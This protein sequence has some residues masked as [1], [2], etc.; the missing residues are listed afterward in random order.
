MADHGL[1]AAGVIYSIVPDR[2][3]VRL[4]R[5]LNDYGIGDLL[6]IGHA[7]AALPQALLGT[8]R[9]GPRQP[10]LVVNLSLGAEIP[11]PARLL[12]RWLPETAKSADQL[13]ARLPELCALLDRVHGNLSDVLAWL[14]ARGVLVV[15]A[16]GND[17]LRQ[18][19][20]PGQPPPPRYPARYDDVLGV[21]AVRRDL[22]QPALYS[23]RGDVVLQ[24]G[25]G[26][27]ATFGGNVMPAA[28]DQTPPTTSP[29]D[30]V[31][32]IFSSGVLPDETANKTGWVKWSGTSF[33]T[34]IVAGLA[35]RLWGTDRSRPPVGL[36]QYVRSFAHDM[37]AGIN[38]NSPLEVP[39]LDVSQA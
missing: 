26:H 21:A 16:A 2:T 23:N 8:D 24:A 5:V 18:D 17:A 19:V 27:V 15:A 4:I 37:H 6:A 10:R 38:P 1:F 30:S 29:D 31:V 35:A 36:A 11:I 3:L 25:S 20:S 22:H 14:T 39:I 12:D 7:L 34:P 28:D 32:G 9:P 33:S 13:A